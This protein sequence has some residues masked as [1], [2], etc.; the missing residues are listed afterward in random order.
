VSDLRPICAITGQPLAIGDI[1]HEGK[2][3]PVR[4]HVL[5]RK[6]RIRWHNDVVRELIVPH[7]RLAGLE[8]PFEHERG[9]FTKALGSDF[10]EKVSRVRIG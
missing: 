8:L 1:E 7:R 3:T 9:A 5:T 4:S 2:L 10:D 6:R